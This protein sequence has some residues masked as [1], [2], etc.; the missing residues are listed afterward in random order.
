MFYEDSRSTYFI[1]SFLEIGIGLI[2]V[3]IILYSI[4]VVF[5]LDRGLLAMGN[6]IIL[7]NEYADVFSQRSGCPHRF[8]ECYDVLWQE[9]KDPRQRFLLCR[10]HHDRCW[11]VP[12]HFVWLL[13]SNV[14][15]LLAIP[16]IH[17][18]NIRILLDAASNRA[19][20]K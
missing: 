8:E 18:D 1:S 19:F 14:R 20:P 2:L 5:F 6:V 3:G 13:G 9:V 4:G 10:L 11:L 17:I 15:T 12:F 7:A 16:L